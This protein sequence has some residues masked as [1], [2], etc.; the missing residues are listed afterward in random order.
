MPQPTLRKAR[1]DVAVAATVKDNTAALPP[2]EWFFE[3]RVDVVKVFS[4]PHG[5]NHVANLSVF[6][7]LD[8]LARRTI[9]FVSWG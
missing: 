1:T 7:F 2:G 9:V 4:D 8:G 5:S 6:D 3:Q